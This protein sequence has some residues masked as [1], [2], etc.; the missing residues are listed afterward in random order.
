MVALETVFLASFS[1]L[2]A[3]V[4]AANSSA[5]V[6]VQ[7]ESLSSTKGVTALIISFAPIGTERAVSAFSNSPSALFYFSRSPFRTN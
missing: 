1:V 3:S 6:I 5:S 4:K 7:S 2:K